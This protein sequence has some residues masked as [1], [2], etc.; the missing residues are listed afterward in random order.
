VG[1]T[2]FVEKKNR[3]AEGPACKERKETGAK[4][5]KTGSGVNDTPKLGYYASQNC[6]KKLAQKWGKRKKKKAP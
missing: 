6:F 4:H 1:I 2:A 3:A 5:Y